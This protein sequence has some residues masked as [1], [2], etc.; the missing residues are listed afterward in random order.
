MPAAQP[1]RVCLPRDVRRLC[2][3]PPC[4]C[5]A[6]EPPLSAAARLAHMLGL[7]L[8]AAAVAGL[9]AYS[10]EQGLWGDQEG[11]ARL[12]GRAALRLADAVDWCIEAPPG[13]LPEVSPPTTSPPA[14]HLQA[15]G[16][17]K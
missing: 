11:T 6:L 5:P 7:V 13:H 9:V 16:K 1:V 4:P 12:Y 2:P 17:N 14:E 15:A 10:N 3:P 8:R